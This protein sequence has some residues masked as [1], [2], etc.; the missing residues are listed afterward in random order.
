MA[1]LVQRLTEAKIRALTKIGL[2]HD[3]GGLYLQIRPGGARSWI[4]RYRLNGRTRDQGL[5]ALTDVSLVKAR[6]KAGAARALVNDGIDPIE[7]TRAQAVIP[8]APKRYSAP[9][10][11]EVAEAYMADRLKRLRSGVHRDQWQQTLR[12]YAYPVIGA[13]PVNTIETNDVLR[14]LKPHWENKC[15]TMA[16]LRGRI[17]RILARATVEGL[18][19]GANPATWKGHLQEALPPRSEVQPVKHFRAMNYQ[20][21]PAFMAELGQIGTMSAISLRFLVLTAARTS[22]VTG[23]RWN[24]IDWHEQTWIVPAARTKANRDHI[25]PLSSGALAVLREVQLLRSSD[26]DLIFPGRNGAAQAPM[27]LL[28]LLQR[29]MGRPVTNHGFRSAFRDWAGDEGVARELAEGV[30]AHAIRDTTEKAYRRKTAVELRRGVMEKWCNFI[31]PPAPT[32]V[33]NIEEARRER[34]TAA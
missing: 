9:T 2:H 4:Y 3:G 17:E 31:L 30:L 5:G 28:M 11:E 10:F 33:V 19:R 14:V 12:A 24:E 20:D 18:R 16:R 6:D 7:H 26:D 34:A 23:A 25:V 8:A 29:R 32:E 1:R 22:E 15:E 27:T 13:L 21:V